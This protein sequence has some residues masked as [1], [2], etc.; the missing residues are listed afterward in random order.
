MKP[1]VL[2]DFYGGQ[3]KS[4]AEDN[5]GNLYLTGYFSDTLT[6]KSETLVPKGVFG[7]F[8]AKLNSNNDI[9]WL[10]SFGGSGLDEP[11]SIHVDQKN[12]IYITG[13]FYNTAD[14]DPD[15]KKEHL[16]YGGRGNGFILKLDDNGNFKWV[17]HI[18]GCKYET[19]HSLDFDKNN[20]V[21][22]IGFYKCNLQIND[23]LISTTET[24]GQ[25]TYILKLSDTGE[26]LWTKTIRGTEYVQATE[27]IIDR[28]DNFYLAGRFSEKLF[29]DD[30]EILSKGGFDVF[31]SKFDRLGNLI[32][33]QIFGGKSNDNISSLCLTNNE[34]IL[35]T[36]SF[37][38]IEVIEGIVNDQ[39]NYK[40]Y[41]RQL[42]LIK[43]SSSGTFIFDR[44]FGNNLEN[45]KY[46]VFTDKIDD[47]YIVGT[48][49]RS[50]NS[51]YNKKNIQITPYSKSDGILIKLS[52]TANY[53]S[54]S[55]FGS[56]EDDLFYEGTIT[57]KGKLIAVGSC[58]SSLYFNGKEILK[59]PLKKKGYGIAISIE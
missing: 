21:F 38:G 9:L 2:L 23:S 29:M 59:K 1:T 41:G 16:I 45:H 56:E 33:Y 50:F 34:N 13:T 12:N 4:V 20:N 22:A 36:G 24:K 7:I 43:I 53:I 6:Y 46:A 3:I 40:S 48:F 18:K 54:H 17:N 55:I 52:K 31:I 49:G 47:I 35:I 39:L 27:I 14:F 15:P 51:K 19:V 11:S 28:D 37:G 57:S 10:K 58:K 42:H 32:W 5:H 25:D 44:I 8:V 26:L 30:L